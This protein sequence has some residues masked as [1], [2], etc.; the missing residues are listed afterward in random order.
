MRFFYIALLIGFLALG[1]SCMAPVQV[2]VYPPPAPQKGYVEQRTS[3]D[4]AAALAMKYQQWVTLAVY[5]LSLILV[6]VQ[7]RKQGQETTVEKA[8]EYCD[9]AH[10][11]TG[12][13]MRFLNML[14]RR[15]PK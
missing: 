2:P 12:V 14:L 7:A 10:R 13:F 5:C 15:R 11:S 6:V 3:M 8:N 1:L 4:R 9:K